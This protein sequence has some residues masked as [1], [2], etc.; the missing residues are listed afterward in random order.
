MLSRAY[1]QCSHARPTCAPCARDEHNGRTIIMR[2]IWRNA[3]IDI[4]I[5]DPNRFCSPARRVGRK[6]PLPVS[7]GKMIRRGRAL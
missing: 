6:L 3:V 7:K 5:A 1:L 4:G 2:V